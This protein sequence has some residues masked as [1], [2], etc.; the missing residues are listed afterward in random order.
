MK[1][2]KKHFRVGIVLIGFENNSV[3]EFLCK[4]LKE[5]FKNSDCEIAY[6]QPIPMYAFNN[7]RKQYNSTKILKDLAIL[8]KNIDF[9]RILGVTNVDLYVPGLNFIF[10]EAQFFGKVALISTYRLKPELYG[11]YNKSLFFQRILK[12]AV[13]ELGHTFGL[14]HCSNP[15]CVMYFSNSIYDTDFKSNNFCSNCKNKLGLL[16]L[17]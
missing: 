11:S 15:K 12:E 13:H 7:L 1:F 9:D 4:R 17:G 8:A 3:I 10:G 16:N 6:I 2:K 14:E 5:L